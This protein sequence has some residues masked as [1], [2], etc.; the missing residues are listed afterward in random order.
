MYDFFSS[1]HALYSRNTSTSI[2][3]TAWRYQFSHYHLAHWYSLYYKLCRNEKRILF[4]FES[5]AWIV[6]ENGG[7][8]FLL[9][10]LLLWYFVAC[11]VREPLLTAGSAMFED[12]ISSSDMRKRIIYAGM[13]G[14]EGND[15][16]H[17]RN[18]EGG[19][20]TQFIYYTSFNL[21]KLIKMRC[22][23]MNEIRVEW[24]NPTLSDIFRSILALYIYWIRVKL[25][26]LIWRWIST[27]RECSG[28]VSTIFF[29]SLILW[30]AIESVMKYVD[31][32]VGEFRR[33]FYAS[34]SENR[35][36]VWVCLFNC[37]LEHSFRA[38]HTHT[39][40]RLLHFSMPAFIHIYRLID[41]LAVFY[42][43]VRVIDT[44]A[45]GDRSLL[46]ANICSW[47]RLSEQKL[48]VLWCEQF[49]GVGNWS[50]IAKSLR[51]LTFF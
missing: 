28:G 32:V 37:L 51:F 30:N 19:L 8:L 20:N 15:M 4:S 21:L 31:S 40:R 43:N 27:F 18:E 38:R 17:D 50:N 7:N 14:G 1:Y 10:L 6:N 41:E 35:K 13:W 33:R 24:I 45:N 16:A 9:L 23:Y 25:C 12:R 44:S 29:V 36:C 11:S 2:Q 49:V 39:Y 46:E 3:W 42:L 34:I 47:N 48:K 5:R 22:N 26:D